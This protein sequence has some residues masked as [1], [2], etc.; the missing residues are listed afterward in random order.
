MAGVAELERG[1]VAADD[2]T[3]ATRIDH[4][5]G[6]RVRE[7]RVM[8]GLSQQRLAR[9]IGV[10]Y[11]Q[12]HKYESGLNRIS[13]GR[14]YEIARVMNVPVGWFFDGLDAEP[15]EPEMAPSQ[16]L[17]LELVRNFGAIP[18][19][20]LQVALVHMIRILA[21]PKEVTAPEK[22]CAA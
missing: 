2:V 3:R 5:V 6:R 4:H 8:L 15:V 9:M 19:E 22:D 7:R 21:E 10:T 1:T 18:N 17:C 12:A 14:L 16:R 20:R 13:G 11:Q